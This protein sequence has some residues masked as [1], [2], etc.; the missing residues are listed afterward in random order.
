MTEALKRYEKMSA[1]WMREVYFRCPV[2]VQDVAFSLYGMV[3]AR[4]RYGPNFRSQL[5]GLKRSE[6]WSQESIVESQN[7]AFC[8]IVRYAYENVPFYKRW[9]DECGVDVK[10]VKSV[11]DAKL[12]PKLTKELVRKSSEDMLSRRYAKRSLLKVSTSGTTGT[13]LQVF[14]TADGLSLQWATWWRHK[15]RVGLSP[16]DSHLTFGARVPISPRQSKPPYWRRDWANRRVYLSVHHLSGSAVNDIVRYLNAT[17][18]D[19]YTGYPSAMYTLATLAEDAG[20]VIHNPPKCIV[21]GSE[22]LLPRYRATLERVF[23]APVTEQYGMAEFAGNL[24]QCEVGSLH[25]DFECGYVEAEPIAGGV[26]NLIMTGWGNLAMPFIRYEVGDVGTVGVGACSCGRKSP[27]F[28]SVD[29]RTSDYVVDIDGRRL[30]G[31]NQ[32]LKSA[33]RAKAMQVWQGR[34]G[35][36]EVRVVS[37]GGVAQEDERAIRREFALRGGEK[38]QVRFAQVSELQRE[39]SGK[40]R[41]VISEL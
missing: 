28:S 14:Q 30:F 31:V 35:E 32:V 16:K 1:E 6:W 34:A 40:V 13:P 18:F 11:D 2:L 23:G 17:D 8:G 41:A 12:L 39:G 19:F 37:S 3:L 27:W 4:R 33:T 29:G 15:A 7:D 9:Y 20:L 22:A 10:R 26:C 36:V 5:E 38:L 21:S 25:V 24:S